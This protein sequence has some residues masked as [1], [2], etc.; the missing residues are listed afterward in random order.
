MNKLIGTVSQFSLRLQRNVLNIA[1]NAFVAVLVLWTL[2]RELVA[3]LLAE[4]CVL[5]RDGISHYDVVTLLPYGV[6]V[7]VSGVGH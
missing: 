4:L 6:L 7:F 1:R 2:V 3:E 5:G